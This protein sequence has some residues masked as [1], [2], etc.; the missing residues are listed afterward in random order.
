[1]LDNVVHAARLVCLLLFS[2]CQ[3][4][5]L[6]CDLT[7]C[8]C[9]SPAIWRC[10]CARTCSFFLSLSL[11]LGL[12]SSASVKRIWALDKRSSVFH[13]FARLPHQNYIHTYTIYR[14]VYVV[15]HKQGDHVND[16]LQRAR[17]N[18]QNQPAKRSTLLKICVAVQRRNG[19]RD[20][21]R[22]AHAR[23]RVCGRFS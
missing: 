6:C 18:H 7:L 13:V 12:W 17:P 15:C 23:T 8:L 9:P 20:M 22:Q 2:V 21:R 5:C 10:W 19:M 16:C 11:F 1:M 4:P 3:H 14:I